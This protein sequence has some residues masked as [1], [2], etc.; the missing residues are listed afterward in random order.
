MNRFKLLAAAMLLALPIISACGED[1]P[2]APPTGSIDGLVSIEGQGLDGVSV[3]LSNGATATTANGG[4]FRFDGVEAGAYTVT[5]SNY[6]DDAT[7]NNT[8]SPATIAS[9]GETVTINFPGTWI[10]TAA[11]MGTVTVE[12][13][14]LPGVTVKLTGM[15]NS[16]TLTDANGQYAFTGLRKGNYTVEISGFDDE[17]V[18]FG[19]TASTAELAVGE[20]R[21]IP[22]EGTY[23]RTSAITGQVSVENVGLENVTVSLQGRDEE[24][25]A[26][27]N[28]A[29]QYTFSELR[30]G[31]YS[32]GIT[33]PDADKYGFDVTSENVTIAHGETGSVSFKGIL[34]RTASIMGTVTVEGV[35]GIE[36]VLVSVQ[37]EGA[38]LE[39]RTNAAGQ[40]SFTELHAG[41]YSIGISGFDDDLYGFEKTT[42]TTT[43]ALQETATVPFSG[44]ELR[45]AGFEGTVTVEDVPIPGVTV[46][47]S[48]GPKDEE[49]TRVTNDAGYYMVD[50]LHAGTYTITISDFDANEYEFIATSKTT[51]VGLRTT[52]TVA[53]QGD[54]LRTA[55][56]SGRVSVAD[57]DMDLDG[58]MVT[59]S[60]DADKTMMTAD[61]GQYAF[62]GLAAGDYNVA[63]SG[64]DEVKYDF[65]DT[66]TSVDQNVMQDS[67]EV[68]NFVGK[69]Q[70]TAMVSGQL[71][72]DEVE[73]DG[74]LTDGE[75]PFARAGVPLL[76]QGPGVGEV[77]FGLTGAD[78]SY[79][80][81]NLIAG[82]YRVLI[83]LNE[84]VVDSLTAYGFRYSGET[85]GQVHTLDAGGEA[86]ADFPIRIVVQTIMAGAVMG[87]SEMATDTRVG[88]VEMMLYPTVEDADAG[89]N[90]LGK[91][92][93]GADDT[94]P[95]FGMATFHFPRA[96]D[97]GPGGQGLDHLV[98]AK[99]VGSGS[100]ALEVADNSHIE[101]QYAGIDRVS[102]APTAARMLNTAV[103]FQLN[104]MSRAEARDGPRAL[105]GWKVTVDGELIGSGEGDDFEADTTAADGMISY[106]TSV[107]IADLG[108]DATMDFAV[109]LDEDTDDHNAM[110]PDGGE[111]WMQS[112]ALKHTH[113][114]LML[115]ADDAADAGS[116]YVTWTTQTL[117]V[118]AYREMDDV[119]GYAKYESVVNGDHRPHSS[120]G[121]ELTVEVLQKVSGRSRLQLFEDWDHDCDG[122]PADGTKGIP[123]SKNFG[124]DGLA[125]FP[126]LDADEEWTVRFRE[127]GDRELVTELEYVETFNSADLAIG[128]T[129]GAFGDMS[130]GMPEVRLCSA[131]IAVIPGYAS[132]TDDELCATWG[133]QWMTASI[134]GNVGPGVGGLKVTLD[135][136]TDAHGA[137]ADDAT[138]SNA[139]ATK[140][141]YGFRGVQ[142]G[143][144]SVAAAGNAKYKV[145]TPAQM[146]HLYHNEACWADPDPDNA[147]CSA[148]ELDGPDA[149][150]KYAYVNAATQ[151]FMTSRL[152]LEVRGFV[153]NVSHEHDE[154]VRGDE[155]APGLQLDIKKYSGKNSATTGQPIPTGAVLGTATVQND[156]SYKF[157]NLDA[158]RYVIIAKNKAGEYEALQSGP[159]DNIGGVATAQDYAEVTDE[160]LLI[161]KLPSWDYANSRGRRVGPVSVKVGSGATAVTNVY[162]NFAL[163]HADGTFSGRVMEARGDATGIAVEL[164]RCETYADDGTCREE[165]DYAPQINNTAGAAGKW[166]FS[167]LREGYYTA[168]VAATNYLR[169][170]WDANG[171]NDDAANCGPN[172]DM[173]EGSD[174]ATCDQYRTVRVIDDLRGKT[175]FNP[176][177]QTFYVYNSSLS[178]NDNLASVKVEGSPAFGDD[179]M[180][181]GATIPTARGAGTTAL[182]LTTTGV[183]YNPGTVKVTAKGAASSKSAS[184]RVGTKP[185][186]G[187]VCTL[188]AAK[189]VAATGAQAAAAV[190]T[191]V[192]IDVVAENGYNDHAYTFVVT[193]A[194]PVD[195]ILTLG[196]ITSTGGSTVSG[197]T[198]EPDL[199][200]QVPAGVI[201]FDLYAHSTGNN[202]PDPA[203]CAQSVAVKVYNGSE[204]L[205]AVADTDNDSCQGEQ[206]ELGQGVY[207]VTVTSED[208]VA[209]SYRLH[210]LK[211]S[212]IAL[213]SLTYEGTALTGLDATNPIYAQDAAHD[214]TEVTITWT[215]PAGAT[216]TVV[217]STD[218]DAQTAGHQVTLG[219]EGSTTD[220][221]LTL[222]SADG[223]NSNTYSIPVTRGT[224]PDPPDPTAGITLLDAEADGS[225]V[226]QISVEEGE[227][228][229]Y[230]VRLATDPG[231]SDANV[232]NE[233]TVTVTSAEEANATVS[234]DQTA[235]SGSANATLVFTGTT[236]GAGA[237]EGTWA[238]PQAVVVFGIDDEDAETHAVSITHAAAATTGTSEEYTIDADDGP[239]L[240]AN[241][242][243]TNTKGVIVTPIGVEAKDEGGTATYTVRLNSAPTGNTSVNLSAN[244]PSGVTVSPLS[245]AFAPNDYGDKTVT[246]TASTDDTDELGDAFAISHAVGLGGGYSG[247]P[248]DPVQVSIKDSDVAQVVVS[249]TAFKTAA[250]GTALTYT[251]FLTEDAASGE[252]VTVNLT[253]PAFAT[254]HLTAGTRSFTLTT[255]ATTIAITANSV[256]THT[257]THTISSTGGGTEAKY[258]S[259]TASS[260]VITVTP[261][262]S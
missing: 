249:A 209:K 221:T 37:G 80:F 161:G 122:N 113:N 174:A 121:K 84:D 74:M 258:G 238:T 21:V 49:H 79:S 168:N 213:T 4:M 94:K 170:K 137:E 177:G 22:F 81:P 207:E 139:A 71:F 236:T 157:E 108:D 248:V 166:S 32:I 28:S 224:R 86:T 239:A 192:T 53:F 48:G 39:K 155:T 148:S 188:T 40:F 58:V 185:C 124:A 72:I 171:I 245:L 91:A 146:L 220:I 131:S 26:T 54:L 253:S 138:S 134:S 243:E 10:R 77:Q 41:D 101:I 237:T 105:S 141:N 126:C 34:L 214:V 15:S 211:G 56:I 85:S 5:I 136:V 47:V 99:V 158:G 90:P 144:Y 118:G 60:G 35:G 70:K 250:G 198:G 119:Y 172:S 194:R 88:G 212:D 247:V 29:G 254:G 189:T 106:S 142:D 223:S 164:R 95:D 182:A 173:P 117:V 111:K 130:G 123:A 200:F 205:E 107:D 55:G 230:W 75:P 73:A 153:A 52:A 196:E 241:V 66:P 203:Y 133:Y 180:D 93:T 27:T 256:G 201:T 186:A 262:S 197:G 9:D 191:T 114:A 30:S 14:G 82:T 190:P 115:P 109:K 62:T 23:L 150:K 210:V 45:T 195:A 219:A 65:S 145:T 228:E 147:A 89:T 120:V 216:V 135:P 64:W 193:R 98:F 92:T 57:P 13:D 235:T 226:A 140:G 252:T 42:A 251:M 184:A 83:D 179:L 110:Q 127:G 240:T 167:P 242:T 160:N 152:G 232:A 218:A 24:R 16:E 132:G 149:D 178:G 67:A 76:L 69:H 33:N 25:T 2:I 116:L 3:T 18:A 7:F 143:T 12:N 229:T 68:V 154:I 19:S 257:V 78:G 222:T 204:D 100:D 8:S 31:D 183:A 125:K 43:V 199:P 96:M 87:T 128:M 20:S 225:P 259:A 156:G 97:L 112:D 181:L 244:L 63:I 36:G 246:I 163:L 46:T 11:I 151:N 38:E 59:L 217:P 175:A 261:A 6:P 202:I 187:G 176:G 129:S 227:N 255:S 50:K 231:E 103:S 215:A 206:Y 234:S 162:H 169:A 51:D 17:D 1:P 159:T 260:T 104:V 102:H 61:G 233:I 44:T 165:L 208:G